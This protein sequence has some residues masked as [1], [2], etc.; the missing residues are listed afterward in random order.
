MVLVLWTLFHQ[1]FLIPMV[2]K[3]EAMAMVVHIGVVET[4]IGRDAEMMTAATHKSPQKE[5]QIM[6]LGGTLTMSLDRKK[7]HGFEREVTLTM[8][9][10]MIEN[11]KLNQNFMLTLSCFAMNIF[12]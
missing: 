12:D 3:V 11:D 2:D 4:T 7:I 5:H 8:M 9:R 10:K 6:I 1:L